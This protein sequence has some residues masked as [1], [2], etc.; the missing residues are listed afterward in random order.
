MVRL[1]RNRVHINGGFRGHHLRNKL[2][3]LFMEK[4]RKEKGE[5]EK[6]QFPS[7]KSYWKNTKPELTAESH[8]K[9]AYCEASTRVV[10]HGD[11]EHYRPKSI[12]WWLAYS[13]ENY[14]FSCQI[15]NQTYKIDNFPTSNQRIPEPSVQANMTDEQLSHILEPYVLDAQETTIEQSIIGL[16]VLKT[17]ENPDLLNPYYDDPELFFRWEYDDVTKTVSL[18][19]EQGN[20]ESKRHTNAAITYLGLNRD[21]LKK[22]RYKEFNKLRTFKKTLPFLPLELRQETESIIHLMLNEDAEF[23]G[24]CRYFN[25]LPLEALG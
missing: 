8:D 1:T 18:I 16:H 25:S 24:M 3:W 21:E 10:A 20:P 11:V 13:Y 23:A 19:H 4:R 15:C 9:C 12:Y 2:R 6:I 22:E 17:Q 14:L 5:I 7:G